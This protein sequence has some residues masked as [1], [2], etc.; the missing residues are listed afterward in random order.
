MRRGRGLGVTLGVAVA[1]GVNAVG[2]GVGV[3]LSLRLRFSCGKSQAR[4]GVGRPPRK[5]Q[6]RVTD[7]PRNISVSAGR[8]IRQRV[9]ILCK[10]GFHSCK[11]T[12]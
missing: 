5:S 4:L 8:R 12:G 9:G 6:R 7:A 11:I 2:V 1:V 3:T 10:N